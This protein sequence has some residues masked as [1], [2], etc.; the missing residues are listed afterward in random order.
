MKV[1]VKFA[2]EGAMKFVG[3]LDIMRYFQKAIRRAGIDIAYSEGFSPH[4]IMSFANP[5]SV[6]L[7]SGGEYFDMQIR[8][9]FPSAELVRRLNDVMVE[10]MR[11]ISAV[12]VPEDKA[13]KAMSLVEAADYRI[14]FRESQP[15][16]DDWQVRFAAFMERTSI[17]IRKKTKKGEKEMEIRPLVYEWHFEGDAVFIKVSSGSS[18]NLR[19]EYLME[20]FFEAEGL[21]LEPFTLMI[22][23]LEIY[24]DRGSEGRHDFCSLEALGQIIE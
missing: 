2:K 16:P 18:D 3:H 15:L 1:R 5:L 22:H 19:P 12:Q 7:T 20:A 8:T 4:M 10:G 6:G 23:R 14:S 21:I 11:V 17:I 9:A 24:V 13:G